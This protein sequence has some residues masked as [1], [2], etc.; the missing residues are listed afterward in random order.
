LLIQENA[1]PEVCSD[2]EAGVARIAP[3]DPALYAHDD[4]GPDDMPRICAPR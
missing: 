2:L 3:E 4:E 1:A